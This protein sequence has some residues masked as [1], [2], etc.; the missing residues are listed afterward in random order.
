MFIYNKSTLFETNI[1]IIVTAFENDEELRALD[2]EIAT[3]QE[4]NSQMES[5]MIKLR[6]QITCMET[7]I[8]QNEKENQ[9]MGDTN[10]N[11]NQC[12][13]Y[14][15]ESMIQCLQNV[16]LP[17]SNEVIQEDNF[18]SYISQL[19]SLCLENYS[20]ENNALFSTVKQ[21]LAGVKVV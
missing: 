5:Q 10:A 1:H 7:K 11:L 3:L 21:A 14:M 9:A 18:E 8:R 13:G 16:Q 19:R 20:S 6:A 17:N 15:K 12:F 2:N 4:T